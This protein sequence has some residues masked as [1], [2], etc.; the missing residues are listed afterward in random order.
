MS[1]EMSLATTLLAEDRLSI[2]RNRSSRKPTQGSSNRHQ[3]TLAG[4]TPSRASVA[5]AAALRSLLVTRRLL[6]SNPVVGNA[7]NGWPHLTVS[8]PEVSLLRPRNRW[9]TLSFYVAC[10]AI[11]YRLTAHTNVTRGIDGTTRPHRRI[12][13]ADH[14]H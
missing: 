6:G 9:P 4:R 11:V 2:P 12:P 1:L 7:S 5:T 8:G 14:A 13:A 3:R 10:Y